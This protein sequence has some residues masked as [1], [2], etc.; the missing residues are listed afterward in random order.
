MALP[1]THIRFALDLQDVLVI[2]DLDAYISGTLYPDSRYFKKIDRELTHPKELIADFL[3]ADDFKKGWAVHLICDRLQREI[4]SEH[5]PSIFD[6]DYDHEFVYFTACKILQDM[7][8]TREF[9]I[10]RHVSSMNIVQ[11]PNEE[12]VEQLEK[13]YGGIRRIYS[14]GG[15]MTVDRLLGIF[16]STSEFEEFVKKIRIQCSEYEKSDGATRMFDM[17]YP[18]MLARARKIL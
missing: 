1:G 16:N 18:E 11:A 5:Q 9:D 3:R 8:D 13:Y 7:C 6:K 4:V 17:I 10:A 14:S 15:I 2:S 12:S